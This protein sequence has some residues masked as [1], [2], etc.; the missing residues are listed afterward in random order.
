MASRDTDATSAGKTAELYPGAARRRHWC[1]DAVGDPAPPLLEDRPRLGLEVL[2][3][4]AI[5][6]GQSAVYS[7]LRIIERMTRGVQLNQQTST[8]N[9]SVTPDRPWLDLAYQLVGIAFALVPA[10]LALYLLEPDRPAGHRGSAS[11]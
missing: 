4:L 7:V 10:L 1:G 11:T 3:V 6:L 2:I 5:S 8:L 9:A